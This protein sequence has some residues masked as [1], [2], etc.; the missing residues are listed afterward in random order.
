LTAIMAN[1]DDPHID[2]IAA[3]AHVSRAVMLLRRYG[4]EGL[5]HALTELSNLIYDL[6]YPAPRPDARFEHEDERRQ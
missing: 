6:A 3:H 2:Y 5:C 4:N 1:G